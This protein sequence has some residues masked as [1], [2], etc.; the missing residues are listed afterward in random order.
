M[1]GT[2]QLD[3]ERPTARVL[4]LAQFA[5]KI[6]AVSNIKLDIAAAGRNHL[7]TVLSQCHYKL[8]SYEAACAEYKD[9]VRHSGCSK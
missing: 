4:R 5:N 7:L 3:S 6:F 2:Q 1:P 9:V 8:P